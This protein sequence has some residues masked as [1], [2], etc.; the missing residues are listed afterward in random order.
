VSGSM[1]DGTIPASRCGITSSCI[2]I[3]Q[4]RNSTA[5]LPPFHN[6]RLSSIAHIHIYV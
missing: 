5:L 2:A 4:K 3:I 6:I 1:V